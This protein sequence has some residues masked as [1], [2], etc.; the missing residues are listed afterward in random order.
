[1]SLEPGS[2]FFGVVSP[3]RSHVLFPL[4]YMQKLLSDPERDQSSLLLYN[5]L[6]AGS[7]PAAGPSE[8]RV[9]G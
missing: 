3:S 5:M 4:H 8:Y 7:L 2:E 9:L 6:K 1:V